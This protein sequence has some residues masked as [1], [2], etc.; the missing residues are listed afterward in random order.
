MQSFASAS[1]RER[2][3]R[4]VVAWLAVWGGV[5]SVIASL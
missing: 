4:N 1:V 5:L 3:Y 2:S